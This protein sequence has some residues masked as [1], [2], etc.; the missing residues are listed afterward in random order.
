MNVSKHQRQRRSLARWLE[1]AAK[2]ERPHVGRGPRYLVDPKV[3]AACAPSLR[4]IATALRND[5]ASFDEA[6]MRSV[7]SF[8]T[9]P[10]SPF[11][12]NDPAEAL[13]EAVRLQHLV[14]DARASAADLSALG[15]AFSRWFVPSC[16]A[17]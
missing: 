14:M 16:L 5:A 9:G 11:Y 17:S 13:R 6:R 12:G 1:R 4:A 2:P 3:N 8:L 15:K 10:D 7:R